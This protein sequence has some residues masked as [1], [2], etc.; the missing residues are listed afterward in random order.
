M[1]ELLKTSFVWRL[2]AGLLAWLRGSILGRGFRKLGRLWRESGFYRFW[3]K[4]LCA[5]PLADQ[6]A[7]ERGLTRFNRFLYR[8]RGIAALIRESC[9]G[10]IYRKLIDLLRG[11]FLLGWMFEGGTTTF[12]LFL[13][14]AYS[15]VDWFLRDV[16]QLTTLASVW[17][18]ALM[19]FCFLMIIFHRMEKPL[20]GRGNSV[21]VSLGFYIT[22]GLLLLL[23]TISNLGV[24][25]TGFRASMQYILLFFLVTRLI[26]DDDDLMFM[27]RVMVMGAFLIALYG[28]LQFVMGVEIPEHWT[29]QAETSVRTRVFAIFSNPNIMG[30][31]MVMFAPM[32]IGMAYSTDDAATRVLYWIAGL[33]MCLACLFTMSRGA[34]MALAAGMVLFALIIDRKLLGLMLLAGIGACFLPFVRSRIGYLFTPDFVESNNRGGRGKRWGTAFSYLDKENSWDMGLGYGIYGGAVAAQNQIN[35]EY[36][37]MYVDNYYVKILVENGIAGLTAFLI[38]MAG[39]LWGGFRACA[40]TS[41]TKGKPLCAGMLAGLVGILLHSFFESIWEEPYMMALFF[42]IAGMI[43]YAGFLNR[44]EESR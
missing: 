35:P 28:I 25:I 44:P 2:F 39:T 30:A 43:V 16:L 33:S 13:I 22:A 8:G 17:D 18:E 4:I 10:R 41:K 38:S 23:C 20:R 15:P 29:E 12:L 19:I 37:Y 34:W 32:A 24:N 42:A 36:E 6:S 1:S 5:E 7:C 27:Y 3:K 9:F 40:R 26:R 31:Y 21:D 14:A 11:S